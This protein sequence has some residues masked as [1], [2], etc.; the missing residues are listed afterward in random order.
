MALSPAGVRLAAEDTGKFVNDMNTATGSVENLGSRG[1]SAMKAGSQVMIGALREIGAGAV[2]LALKGGQ[3]L[4]GFVVDG[5]KAAGDFDQTMNVLQQTVGATDEDMAAVRQTAKDL[6]NDL[7][8]PATSAKDAGEAMLELGKAGFTANEAMTAAKGVLSLAAAGQLEEAKAAEITANTLH[9]F[10][11]EASQSGMVADLLAASANASSLSVEDMSASVANAG[12]VFSAMQGPAVGAKGSLVELTTATALL[13]NAGM[14]GSDAGTSLKTMMLMLAAPTDKASALMKE[15]AQSVGATGDIA[16]DAQGKMR[17]MPEMLDLVAKS[18]ANMTEQ[19][20][21]AAIAQIFG[22]DAT[23]A[24]LLLLKQGPEAY[25]KMSDAVQKSG[26]ANDAAAAQMKGMNG[27]VA[28]AKNAL[29]TFQLTIGEK[30]MPLVTNFANEVISPA[31]G[32]VS[33]FA[34]AIFGNK[35]A[36]DNLSPVVQIVVKA[37]QDF[38][39]TIGSGGGISAALKAFGDQIGVVSPFVGSL[40]TF[41]GNV[42]AAAKPLADIIGQNLTPILEALAIVLTGAVVVALGAMVAPLIAPIA[43]ITGLIAVGALLIAGWNSDFLGIRTVVTDVFTNTL[44]PAFTAV[45]GWVGDNLPAATRTLSDIWSNVLAPILRVVWDIIAHFL[46]PVISGIVSVEFAALSKIVEV[47]GALIKNV[48]VP[49]FNDTVDKVKSNQGAMNVLNGIL[50][51]LKSSFNWLSDAVQTFIGWLGKAKDAINSIHVPAWLQGGSPPPMAYWFNDISL[52]IAEAIPQLVSFEQTLEDTGTKASKK[53][54]EDVKKSI[55]LLEDMQGKIEDLIQSSLEAQAGMFD[56]DLGGI[57]FSYNLKDT[58]K[59]QQKQIDLKSDNKKNVE[60]QI[61]TAGK[62]NDLNAQAAAHEQAAAKNSADAVKNKR[63]VAETQGLIADAESRTFTDQAARTTLLTSLNEKLLTYQQAYATSNAEMVKDT[64]LAA[65]ERRRAADAEKD[66]VA[67]QYKYT[68]NQS[69]IQE[70]QQEINAITDL[71]THN[72]EAM[73]DAA[74][75]AGQIGAVDAVTGEKYYKMQTDYIE[76]IGGL[77]KKQIEA[78]SDEERHMYQQQIDAIEGKHAVDLKLFDLEVTQ[79]E[80]SISKMADDAQNASNAIG[81]ATA[82]AI[83]QAIGAQ[84]QAIADA[85]TD[86]MLGAIKQ[87]A[88]ALEITSPSKL[89]YRKLGIP[90]MQGITQAMATASVGPTLMRAMV[91]PVASFGQMMSTPSTSYSSSNV[92]NYAPTYAAAPV[93]PQQD[94][95][96]MRAGLLPV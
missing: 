56:I 64:Q 38:A 21:S 92:Y 51:G 79:R 81:D 96:L 29:E 75:R 80:K 23:R 74:E 2:D 68:S 87:A 1:S 47:V 89:T 82:S 27:A 4:V 95:Y 35:K 69:Y 50:G 41:L 45:A 46:V 3:A 63:L 8:L 66:L 83:V 60:D 31:I 53:Q 32:K 24:V 67:L 9:A 88:S 62:F 20:R 55:A 30:V 94:F 52:S 78:S 7:S 70:Q 14:S 6:G 44:V 42:V 22:A 17:P 48:L 16:F 93:A 85:L 90:F 34:E 26:A 72:Q 12:A 58:T 57:E 25:D 39:S 10:G 13:G 19:D 71:A 59:Q 76:K 84:E 77:K 33:D 11:L 61:A 43:I 37:I 54:A 40:S 86:A 18:T 28:A 15:L 5:V 73:N 36:F 91:E 49:A 65:D